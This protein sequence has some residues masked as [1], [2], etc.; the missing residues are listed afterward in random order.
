MPTF[1]VYWSS[2][3][4]CTE[5]G[6]RK[7]LQNL[8]NIYLS[9][10]RRIPNSMNLYYFLFH[11]VVICPNVLCKSCKLFRYLFLCLLVSFQLRLVVPVNL[12]HFML[13]FVILSTSPNTVEFL[14]SFIY[15]A[16]DVRP[17]FCKCNPLLMEK[18][19]NEYMNNKFAY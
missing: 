5:D 4:D 8:L 18:T 13:W 17:G 2:M 19:R 9:T 7:I 12:P 10:H 11:V 15:Y 3:F 1:M 14:G 16:K 6:C